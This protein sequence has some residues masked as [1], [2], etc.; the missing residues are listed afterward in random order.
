MRVLKFIV[1]GKTLTIDP[2]S[3]FTGLFPG[4]NSDVHAEFSFS[5]EW[6]NRVKVAAFWSIL[7][8]EYPPQLLN[9][10]N[11]C[12]I[13]VEALNKPSFKVGILGKHRG[14]NFKTNTVTVHQR[15]GSR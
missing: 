10:E 15:G 3:D 1:N 5:P 8:N 2:S 12:K 7:N 9:E 11:L 14:T 6:G 4:T 13:P